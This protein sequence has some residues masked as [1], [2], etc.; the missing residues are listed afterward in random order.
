M[1]TAQAH[2]FISSTLAISLVGCGISIV[3][4]SQI[5]KSYTGWGS[6]TKQRTIRMNV[7]VTPIVEKMAKFN[8]LGMVGEDS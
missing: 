6:H 1:S 4:K 5:R 8:G 3:E 7:R 2:A